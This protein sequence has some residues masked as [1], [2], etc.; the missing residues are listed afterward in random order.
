MKLKSHA[1]AI[2]L[3]A[4]MLPALGQQGATDHAAHHGASAP[5]GADMTDGEIRKVDKDG[6]KVTIKH[7]EIKNIEMPA[8]TMVFQVKDRKWLD[9]LQAGDKVRFRAEKAGSGGYVVT[10]IEPAR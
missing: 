10:A 9:Q 1:F 5:A 3:A 7:G 8:M 6:A 2:V 4:A